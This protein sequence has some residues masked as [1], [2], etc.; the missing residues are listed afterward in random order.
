MNEPWD[1]SRHASRVSLYRGLI[2]LAWADHELHH[3]E[4][5]ALHDIFDAHA[6]LTAENRAVLHTEV[7]RS[8]DLE[9]VWPLITDVQDRARLIDMA[10]IIFQQDG[11]Y[12]SEERAMIHRFTARHLASVNADSIAQEMALLT[13]AQKAARE[14]EREDMKIWASQYSI[15]GRLKVAFGKD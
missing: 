5:A 7:D 6:G 1:A 12:S 2:A 9:D 13:D 8:I 14:L 3:E 11:N 15:I 10:N 4:K